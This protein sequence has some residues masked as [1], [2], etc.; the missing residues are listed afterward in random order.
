MQE[1]TNRIKSARNREHRLGLSFEHAICVLSIW[2]QI[3]S[4]QS[5]ISGTVPQEWKDHWQ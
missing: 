1:V 2:T 4:L 3:A 5:V